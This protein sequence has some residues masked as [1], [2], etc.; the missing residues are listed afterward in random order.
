[1]FKFVLS[2]LVLCAAWPTFAADAVT[3]AMQKAYAPYRVALF[4]T[5]SNSQAE[6]QQAVSQAQQAWSQLTAR[7]GAKPPAP[8]ERDP[9]FAGSLAEVDQVYAQAAQEIAKNQLSPAHETLE[10]VRDIL[11][12]LRQRNQVIVYSD[13]MNAYHAEM[14]HILIGGPK[15]LAA[16]NGFLQLGLQVGVLE[17]LAHRLRTEAPAEYASN[18]EFSGLVQAVEAS[19]AALKA[20]VLAQ[21]SSASKQALGK[22]KP[23]YSKLFLKFG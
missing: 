14:E 19:V 22:M 3:E 11:S 2:V 15:T 10:R 7:F 23:A 6:S 13:H 16:P 9:A 8:Y 5:N 17:Y 4:K 1:M 20:A 21:D 18:A 12:A